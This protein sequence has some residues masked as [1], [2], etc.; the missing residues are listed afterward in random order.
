MILTA[1]GWDITADERR[2]LAV[3]ESAQLRVSSLRVVVDWFSELKAKVGN[4]HAMLFDEPL[5][6]VAL[7]E[8]ANHLSRFLERAETGMYQRFP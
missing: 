4:W 6:I 2:V 3:S 1:A 7:D 5:T 8:L